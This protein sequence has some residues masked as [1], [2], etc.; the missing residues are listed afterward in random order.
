LL[1]VRFEDQI[2]WELEQLEIEVLSAEER[3]EA[4][5]GE[6]FDNTNGKMGYRVFVGCLLMAMSQLSGINAIM[7][8]APSTLNVYFGT[9]TSIIGNLLRMIINFLSTFAIFF[10][11]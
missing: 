5:W 7:F 9:S 6:V 1:K 2:D 8:Y 3:G 11:Y 10:L 4:N